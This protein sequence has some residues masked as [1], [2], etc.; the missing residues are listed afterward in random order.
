MKNL[1]CLMSRGGCSP[2]CLHV[3]AGAGYFL[4]GSVGAV[5]HEVVSAGVG[6]VG[7]H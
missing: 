6:V 2:I 1:E 4:L 3:G 7:H 5:V